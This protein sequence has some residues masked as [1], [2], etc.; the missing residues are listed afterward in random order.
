MVERDT[1]ADHS[2]VEIGQPRRN[3][4]R[5]EWVSFVVSLLMDI[6]C[7]ITFDFVQAVPSPFRSVAR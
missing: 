3:A 6:V 7:G 4:S 1:V 5:A 2:N